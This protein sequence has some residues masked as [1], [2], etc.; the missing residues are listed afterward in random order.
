LRRSVRTLLEDEKA[1]VVTRS[2]KNKT[3]ALDIPCRFDFQDFEEKS[4][5]AIEAIKQGKPEE[6][7]ERA[8]LA[9]DLYQ[10]CFLDGMDEGWIDSTR[11]RLSALF[12]QVQMVVARVHLAR[13]D[14]QQAESASRELIKLDD[15]REEAHVLLIESLAKVGRSA[16]AVAHYEKA[17]ELFEE[18]IGVT[19]ESLRNALVELGLLL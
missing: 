19:P 12:T 5:Q 7:L 10:G 2:R 15:L 8:S 3:I 16:E 9:L 1:A 17:V 11:S 4:H 13:G 6:A 14:F 18:E